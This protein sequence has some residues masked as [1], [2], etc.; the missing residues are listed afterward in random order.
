MGVATRH[1]RRLRPVSDFCVY[2]SSL[3]FI[4]SRRPSFVVVVVIITSLNQF[5][6]HVP[7]ALH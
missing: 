2:P 3:V 1:T 7:L 4:R 6:I 5:D